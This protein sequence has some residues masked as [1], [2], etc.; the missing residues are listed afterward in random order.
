VSIWALGGLAGRVF[1]EGY[2]EDPNKHDFHAAI[3]NFLSNDR[4][5]LK[6]ATPHVF[7]YYED[8]NSEWN[9]KDD[10]YVEADLQTIWEHVQLG[11]EPH[12]SRRS[13]GDG[14]IYISL[15]CNCDWEPEHGLQLVFKEGRVVAKVGPYD[16]HLT[17]IPVSLRL[18]RRMTC[19][20]CWDGMT[21]SP[22]P[23]Q[24]SRHEQANSGLQQTRRSLTLATRS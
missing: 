8:T 9:E 23:E 7:R 22:T 6:E 21:L 11:T 24:F 5:L 10:E 12:V 15:E 17:T 19:E 3:A 1:L 20:H 2:E 14:A 16:G 4:D 13:R 18:C